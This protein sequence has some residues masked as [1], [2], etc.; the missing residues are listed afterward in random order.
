MLFDATPPNA[1]RQSYIRESAHLQRLYFIATWLLQIISFIKISS[2][3]Y[4]ASSIK[5]HVR[6]ALSIALKPSIADPFTA[7]SPEGINS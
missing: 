6:E 4:Q 2:I 3:K 5:L 1:L 7:V